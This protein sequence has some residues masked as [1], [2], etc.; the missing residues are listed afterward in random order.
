MSKWLVY[1]ILLP[2]CMFISTR[3]ID[4][5][6][7]L[8]FPA[9]FPTAKKKKNFAPLRFN[10]GALNSTELGLELLDLDDLIAK[11]WE[12]SGKTSLKKIGR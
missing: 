9:F 5:R 11:S 6:F 1:G 4:T 2:T 12:I 8:W 7:I 10:K 3:F